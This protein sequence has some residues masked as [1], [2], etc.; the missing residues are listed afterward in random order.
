[1]PKLLLTIILLLAAGFSKSQNTAWVKQIGSE[2]AEGPTAIA[3][4]RWGNVYL[5]GSFVDSTDFDPGPGVH[6]VICD[7][8]NMFIAKYDS[9]AHIK[10]VRVFRG[11]YAQHISS[12]AVDASGGI[13]AIGNFSATC[14]FDPGPGVYNATAMAIYSDMFIVKLDSSANFEWVHTYGYMQEDEA[15][16]LA[17]DASDNVYIA[18][19]FVQVGYF[20]TT[21]AG[22]LQDKG[23]GD[24]F[25]LKLNKTGGFVWVKQIGGPDA[26]HVKSVHLDGSGNIYLTGYYQ[27]MTDFDPGPDSFKVNSHPW[28]PDAFV[29]KLDQSGNFMWVKTAGG[30]SVLSSTSGEGITVDGQGNILV[31]GAFSDSSDFDPG[32]GTHMLYSSGS[33]DGFIWKL[34]AGGNFLWVRQISAPLWDDA[35]TIAVDG[36]NSIYFTGLFGPGTDFDPG[37]A[38]YTLNAG[39]NSN[40]YLCK[41]DASGNFGWAKGI[42][43]GVVPALTMDKWGN[44]YA[45]C[46]L[47][48]TTFFDGTQYISRGLGDILLTKI[49]GGIPL[50]VENIVQ[51]PMSTIYPNP[52]SEVLTIKSEGGSI[53]DVVVSDYTGNMVRAQYIAGNS[54]DVGLDGLVPGLYFVRVNKTVHK[55]IKK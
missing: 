27:D 7:T 1:M 50:T 47:Y 52:A 40:A 54:G 15:K 36:A 28:G 2:G 23:L 19:K 35:R 44:V 3:N 14:D 10:W 34:D 49:M 16:G 12:L 9:S 6:T 45:T 37:P 33:V 39:Y 53:G 24:G 48:D 30:G 42:Q 41:L 31:S 29:C 51:V 11:T 32:P 22:V 8:A 43:R 21:T 17:I 13:Y 20:D 18:G 25:L 4:D 46:N 55:V 26:Q 38:T 5:S